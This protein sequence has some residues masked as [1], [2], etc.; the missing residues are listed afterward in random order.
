MGSASPLGNTLE[1]MRQV[2]TQDH[3]DI[4]GTYTRHIFSMD[5]LSTWSLVAV[6]R[7]D[8]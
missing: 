7:G 2:N 4:E 1:S 6:L 3:V 8:I 5:T